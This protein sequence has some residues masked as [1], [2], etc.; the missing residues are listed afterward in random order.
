MFPSHYTNPFLYPKASVH[1]VVTQ[2]R[3]ADRKSAPL[4]T[5]FEAFAR[6]VLASGC[7]SR[8][9]RDNI[10]LTLQF[11]LPKPMVPHT[12][13]LSCTYCP[14]LSVTQ[15]HLLQGARTSAQVPRVAW[16]ARQREALG[17]ESMLFAFM[18][19]GI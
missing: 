12:L 15:M 2:L 18:A 4:T 19:I 16:F 8:Q 5:E 9:A 14:F 1:T 7:S 11:V 6:S 13:P 17:L 3:C 10:L